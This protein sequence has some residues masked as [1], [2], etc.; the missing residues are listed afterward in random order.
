MA[1]VTIDDSMNKKQTIIPRPQYLSQLMDFKDMDVIKVVTGIRRCGKST[2][3]RLFAEHLKEHGITDDQIISVNFESDEFEDMTDRKELYRYVKDRIYRNGRTYIFLDE[4]QAVEGFEKTVD[5]FMADFDADIY[6]TGSNSK[7]LSSDLSTLLSGRCVEIRMYPLSFKEYMSVRPGEHPED[8]FYDYIRYGGFP[9][10]ADEKG[11]RTISTYLDGLYNTI[12][13]KDVIR[14]NS[15]KDPA[16]IEKLIRLVFSSV[17]SLVSPL[18]I[19]N[20]IGGGKVSNET[21][22]SYLDMLCNAHIISKAVRYDIKGK[23]Y[24]KTLNKY[25]VTDMGLRNNLMNYRQVEP[26][27]ALENI[28]Y[29]ELLRR[30]Y[31]VDVGKVGDTEVDFV[32]R[33]GNGTKYYQVAWTVNDRPETAV[34]EYRAFDAIRDHYEKTLITMDRD[35]F[36]PSGGVKKI[37]AIDFLLDGA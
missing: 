21:I 15:I 36:N 16:L 6:L 31:K 11:E 33:D 19:A 35:P 32:A 2:L 5:S 8:R 3:L 14:R 1:A 28:I 13:L 10:I 25:Y 23:E 4:I 30:G 37:N 24:L 27:R 22:D 9:L 20:T 12:V 26:T 17:G 34:R 7:M 29:F 18:S